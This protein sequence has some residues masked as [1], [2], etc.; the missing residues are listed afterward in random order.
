MSNVGLTIF[1]IPKI[2]DSSKFRILILNLF[3]TLNLFLDN[4]VRQICE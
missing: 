4:I 2:V 1:E 3:K